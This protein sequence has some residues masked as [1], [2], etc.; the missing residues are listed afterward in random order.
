MESS[1]YFFNCQLLTTAPRLEIS[2][3]YKSFSKITECSW[4]SFLAARETALVAEEFAAVLGVALAEDDSAAVA[5][6]SEDG[7]ALE[8][9]TGFCCCGTITGFGAKNFAQSKITAME[10]SEAT[11]MRIS[12]LSLPCSGGRLTSAPCAVRRW[13]RRFY[14]SG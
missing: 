8:V 9:T 2:T 10:R 1:R 3:R 4:E 11:R 5:D 14:G 7:E 12:A 6:F 13:T